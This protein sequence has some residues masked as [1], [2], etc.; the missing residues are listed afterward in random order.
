MTTVVAIAQDG[1]ITMGAD[2]RV[3]TGWTGSQTVL[4]KVFLIR[5]EILIGY[6][7][8]VRLGNILAAEL[9]PPERS[10]SDSDAEYVIS[11][12]TT[13]IQQTLADNGY[14]KVENEQHSMGESGLLIGYRGLL[15]QM[16]PDF[17]VFA[18]VNSYAA[19]G[20]GDQFALGVL[21]ATRNRRDTHRRIIAALEASS[22]FDLWTA[23]PWRVLRLE[24]QKGSA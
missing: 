7:G 12:L 23:P 6:S 22:H 8:A 9:D 14:L 1:V 5:N 3:T 13:A 11:S 4:P 24:K 10:A 16:G 2:S 15:Y 20:S 18:P 17:G 21:H 19:L